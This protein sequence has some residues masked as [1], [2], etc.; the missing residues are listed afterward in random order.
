MTKRTLTLLFFI[1]FASITVFA[2][3]SRDSVRHSIRKRHKAKLITQDT[4]AARFPVAD[5]TPQGIEDLKQ[6]PLDLKNPDN[7]VT[8]TIYN[9]EDSV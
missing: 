6:L 8:D 7:I 2:Q 5:A 9:A 3:E 1:L 4:V